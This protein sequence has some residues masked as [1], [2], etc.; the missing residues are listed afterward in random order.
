[1]LA[2]TRA[3]YRRIDKRHDRR[4]HPL[5]DNDVSRPIRQHVPADDAVHRPL[6]RGG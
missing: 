3:T 4:W 1:M 5:A 2:I 6:D